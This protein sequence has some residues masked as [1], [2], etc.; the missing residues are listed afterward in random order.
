[1]ASAVFTSRLY[2]RVC[3]LLLFILASSA[4]F[5]EFYVRTHFK[6]IHSPSSWY[7]ATFEGI[8]D[9]T[10]YRPYVYRRLLPDFISW[11]DHVAPEP[12]KARLYRRQMAEPFFGE[13]SVTPAESD[14]V[15]FFRYLL[16][17]VCTVFSAFLAVCFMY[18]VCRAV[19]LPPPASVLAA[20]VMILLVPY[21]Q[22]GGGYFYDYPELAL[23]SLAVWFALKLDWWFMIPVVILGTWNKESFFLFL[24][25]LYPIL[26][27]KNSAA[28]TLIALVVMGALSA[29]VALWIRTRFALN[30]GSTVYIHWA[31]EWDLITHPRS[32][33][34]KSEQVYG[35]PVLGDYTVG[36]IALIAWS[37]WRAW[38]KLPLM[39]RRH[40]QIAAMI[41]IPLYILFVEPGKLRDLSMLDVSL[42]I[43]LAVNLQLWMA[44]V[45]TSSKRTPVAPDDN[46]PI[47]LETS[48]V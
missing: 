18:Q 9:G 15:Y 37:V 24:P 12:L 19:D 3:C 33:I 14:P 32:L 48:A 46:T 11:V 35:I 42:L 1:M 47:A 41:N 25:T 27:R 22:D 44:D 43:V 13:R 36:P 38:K 5:N 7:K 26:R 16:L 23:L 20:V 2:Y 6:E 10:A 30:P 39:I 21:F 4:S 8:I 17:Y 40:A 34:L 28:R 29:A 45:G 31:D